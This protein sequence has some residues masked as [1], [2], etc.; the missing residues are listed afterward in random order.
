MSPPATILSPFPPVP[1]TEAA[2]PVPA[3]AHR[4][5][6]RA[7]VTTFIPP[8]T[9]GNTSLRVLLNALEYFTLLN[10]MNKVDY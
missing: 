10:F 4:G 6:E 7:Q 5:G 2:A 8:Q 1:P 9:F 3:A